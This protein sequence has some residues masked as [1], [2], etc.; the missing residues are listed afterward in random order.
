MGRRPATPSAMVSGRVG[1]D[2]APLAPRVCHR[3]CAQRLD[4]DHLDF[5]RPGLHHVTHAGG[6]R[7]AA[8]SDQDGV[9]RRRGV[10]QFQ[11]DGRR[12]LAGLDVQA[13]FDQPDAVVPR[14]GRRPLASHLEVAVHQLQPGVQCADAIKLGRRRKA[15]CHDGDVEPPAAT[16]PGEGLAKVARAGAH[17]GSRAIVGEQ[18]RDDLGAAGLEAADRVRRFELDAHRAPEAGLQ[19]LAAVQRSVEK[20]RVDHPASRPDPGSVE[21]RLLHDTAA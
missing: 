15:G 4:A 6:Q 7:P 20:N 17:H 11:A 10:R 21:A 14:D 1:G 18:A 16:G 13:V 19:R 9:E 12:A 5:G 8:Q 3:R 2:D